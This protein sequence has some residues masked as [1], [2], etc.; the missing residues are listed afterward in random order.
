MR[1]QDKT[2][3]ELAELAV[4]SASCSEIKAKAQA[5]KSARVK[6]NFH[7]LVENVQDYAIFC[8]IRTDAYQLERR[9]RI[10]GYESAEIIGQLG[11]HFTRRPER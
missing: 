7:L 1:D 6:S 11:L 3:D 4:M 2:K 8:W 10:L 9:E 5:Q